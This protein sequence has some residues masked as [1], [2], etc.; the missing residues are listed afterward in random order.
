MYF[1]SLIIYAFKMFNSEQIMFIWLH[2]LR[3]VNIKTY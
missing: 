1:K 3:Y 2:I